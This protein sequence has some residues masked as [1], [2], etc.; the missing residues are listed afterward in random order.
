MG[1]L[2]ESQCG[3]MIRREPHHQVEGWGGN[4][5]FLHPMRNLGF[6]FRLKKATS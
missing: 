5:L 4:P 6:P 3:G 2:E 1:Y